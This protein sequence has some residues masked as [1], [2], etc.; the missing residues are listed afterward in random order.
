MSVV[1]LLSSPRPSIGKGGRIR[2]Q[3]RLKTSFSPPN[4]TN[5]PPQP[6]VQRAPS[7]IQCILAAILGWNSSGKR[8]YL[9]GHF[10]NVIEILL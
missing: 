8:L 2:E 10:S 3:S 5:H 6:Q 1:P 4:V 7:L 9:F